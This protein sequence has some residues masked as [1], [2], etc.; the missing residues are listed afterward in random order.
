MEGNRPET[1]HSLA[2]RQPAGAPPRRRVWLALILGVLA[3]QVIT[4]VDLSGRAGQRIAELWDRSPVHSPG[5]PSS[6]PAPGEL[7]WVGATAIALAILCTIPLLAV[8]LLAG[9]RL[10]VPRRWVL[11]VMLAS[12]VALG[13]VAG[14]TITVVS[15]A[16]RDSELG[17][18][19]ISIIIGPTIEEAAKLTAVALVAILALRGAVGLRA[20]VILGAAAGVGATILEVALYSQLSYAAGTNPA[21]G[22]VL[23]IRLGLL[24]VNV[25]V[26]ATALGAA[27]LGAWLSGGRRSR[28]P[29]VM[30][31]AAAV[32]SHAAWNLVGS[33]LATAFVLA[34]T[35]GA[36]WS[37]PE[38]F[39][40]WALVV[41]SSAAQALVLAV[42][43]A[44]LGMAWRRA[45]RSD[46]DTSGNPEPSAPLVSGTR[47]ASSTSEGS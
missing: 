43:L 20:A 45:G 5:I 24:G 37:A 42:P 39:P 2:A 33:D 1:T 17:S 21:Y 41:A 22:S 38:P 32:S 25:H 29:L 35:P 15:D 27:G 13:L 31:T 12:A 3:T 6:P 47:V 16:V 28:W 18:W 10:D 4:A 7:F 26:V 46:P 19:A 44:V 36:D 11:L 8:L 14:R 23:A 30:G 9:R 40:L 34:L